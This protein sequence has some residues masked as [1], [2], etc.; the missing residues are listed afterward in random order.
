MPSDQHEQHFYSQIFAFSI[1]TQIETE[2]EGRGAFFNFGLVGGGGGDLNAW[3]GG[4]DLFDFS[5]VS[6]L[7]RDRKKRHP[8]GSDICPRECR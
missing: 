3:G 1:L 4:A 5:R 7:P 6:L 2:G 8:A